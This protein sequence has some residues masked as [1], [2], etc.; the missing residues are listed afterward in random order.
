MSGVPNRQRIERM[1]R[2]MAA[3]LC[4]KHAGVAAGFSPNSRSWI[5]RIAREPAFRARVESLIRERQWNDPNDLRWVIDR[6]E[7][8]A[9]AGRGLGGVAGL[10]LAERCLAHAAALKR[11]LP[12]P[13]APGELSEAEWRRAHGPRS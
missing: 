8:C 10:A 6:M 13:L 7:A 1:A 4:P 9:E 12:P 11:R 2:G 3:G 5:Y